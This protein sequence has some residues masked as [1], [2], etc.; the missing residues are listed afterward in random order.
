[1]EQEMDRWVGVASAVLQALYRATGVKMEQTHEG[2]EII[3]YIWPGK[4]NYPL[5]N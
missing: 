4:T 3:Y 5:R 1:M 2:P